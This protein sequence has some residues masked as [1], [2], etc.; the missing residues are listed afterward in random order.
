[1]EDEH[2][3]AV[4]GGLE[5]E[6]CRQEDMLKAADEELKRAQ[7]K[8]DVA[9][10]K[11]AAIRD[12]LTKYL[13]YSPYEKGHGEVTEPVWNEDEIIDFI[14]YG[15]YRF[16][17][18]TI[19]NAVIAALREAEEPLALEDIVQKL[20]EGGIRKSESPLT[21]AVNAALMRTKGIQKTKDGE[22]FY[23]RE[24]KTEAEGEDLPF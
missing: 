17:H 3:K 16:M 22:Y 21:R 8:F 13:G 7:A 23:P 15:K 11:Y 2:R 10:R 24:V 1:M 19:G 6:L 14:L 20:R 9:S 5:Q 12:T 4:V 18:M